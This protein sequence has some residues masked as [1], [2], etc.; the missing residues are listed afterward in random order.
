VVGGTL[1]T[2]VILAA[3]LAPWLAPFDPL[4]QNLD[5]RLQPPSAIHLFGTD[6]LGRD[7]LSRLIFGCRPVLGLVA[8]VAVVAVP[9]GLVVGLLSGFRGGWT[10]RILMRFTD[11]V[12]AFPHLVLAMALV[13]TLGPGLFNAAF[14]LAATAWPAYARQARTETRVLR[15]S[16]YLK[17][18]EMAGITGFRLMRGHL[19][20]LILPSAV[21]RLSL[22]MAG[23]VV[24][25]AGLGFLGLGIRPP[26]PEWGA[27]VAEGSRVIFDQ[28]WVA[29]V[30]GAAVLLVSL[31]FNLLSEGLRDLWDPRHG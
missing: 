19:L 7:L 25:A 27:M 17:A 10:D 2:V 16:D 18:S 8:L 28:W 26:T 13:G 22:D 9:F 24:A 23:M 21:V 1:L 11:I 14:A 6:S 3:L 4:M 20:P 12:L 5:Q 15:Q 29:T 30:P 31:S